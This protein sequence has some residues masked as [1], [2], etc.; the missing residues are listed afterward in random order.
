MPLFKSH[1][2]PPAPAPPPPPRSTGF[3][4]RRAPSAATSASDLGNSDY[5]SAASHPDADDTRSVRSGFFFGRRRSADSLASHYTSSSKSTAKTGHSRAASQSTAPTS[6]RS[7]K[8]AGGGS[9]LA[10]T[11]NRYR[12]RAQEDPSVIAARQNIARAAEA[13][14][15]ADRALLHARA[16]AREA[17]NS[18]KLLEDEAQAEAK[19]AKAKNALARLVG[20]DASALGRHGG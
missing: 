8:S 4:S 3:F 20:K 5:R 1:P 15:E 11:L 2:E 6:P 10:S 14:A 7:V 16:R 17:M 13:E 9:L 12:G 19:H 18:V